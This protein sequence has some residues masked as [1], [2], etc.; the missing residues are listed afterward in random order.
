MQTSLKIPKKAL[1]ISWMLDSSDLGA[2]FQ[3]KW[4]CD[5]EVFCDSMN[6][7]GLKLLSL[8]RCSPILSPFTSQKLLMSQNCCVCAPGAATVRSSCHWEAP[9][10]FLEQ[11]HMQV[12]PPS[13]R[14][15][16][17]CQYCSMSLLNDLAAGVE[18]A[19]IS[20]TRD[21]SLG[22]DMDVLAALATLQQGF[23]WKEKWARSGLKFNKGNKGKCKLLLQGCNKLST[24]WG[25]KQLGREGAGGQG[26]AR[27]NTSQ[28]SGQAAK[29]ASRAWAALG[30]LPALTAG[31]ILPLLSTGEATPAACV[32]IW[33]PAH[34]RESSEGH[35]YCRGWN[36]WPW[37]LPLPTFSCQRDNTTQSSKMCS[38]SQWTWAETKEMFIKWGHMSQRNPSY[39]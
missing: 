18:W 12:Q 1:N 30:M 34:Q 25:W 4:F 20:F 21:S 15:Q 9:W 37:L 8:R 39:W 38:K 16:Y 36:I 3:P 23:N 10:I 5:S 27:L 33:A 35:K 11:G 13:L 19:P 6:C 31:E 29:E 28:H 17:W 7:E 24:G 32:Q 22:R 2:L 26:G 14:D